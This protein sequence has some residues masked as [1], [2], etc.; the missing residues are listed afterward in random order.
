MDGGRH[1]T[2]QTRAAGNDKQR[3]S[4]PG[5]TS[6]IAS[7][8][9]SPNTTIVVSAPSYNPTGPPQ[10]VSP[11]PVPPSQPNQTSNPTSAPATQS[12]AATASLYQC[13]HCQRRYSRP[14][15]LARHIQTHTLGKRF[16]CQ[17]CGKAFARQDLLKRHVAN[18]E[19]DND[20]NKKRR[21]TDTSPGAGRVSH[22]CRPCATARVKCEEVKPCTRCRNRNLNCEYT[23]TEAGS[24]AAMHLLHL[25][26]NPH[27]T[28]S[29]PGSL[30]TSPSQ[31]AYDSSPSTAYQ[32]QQQ[33]P[34][35]AMLPPKHENG[36]LGPAH[37]VKLETGPLST[38]ENNAMDRAG[39]GAVM[40]NFE[41]GNPGVDMTLPFS[42]FLQNVIYEPEMD[43]SRITEAQGLAVLDFCD[44]SNL[45][46]NE[47][48]FG[49]LDHW[50]MDGMGNTGSN[51]SFTPRTDDSIDLV[52]MRQTLVKVW[53]ES[54]WQWAPNKLDSGYVEHPNFSV[55]SDDTSSAAFQESR[56][57]HARIVRD[58]LDQS[59]R[60]QILAI[61]L[62]TCKND[63]IMSRVA[64]SFPSLEVMDSLIHIFLASHFCQTSQWIHHGSFSM[65]SQWPEWLAV[66]AS[67]GATL[68]PVQTLRKFGF[69]LQEAVRVTIPARFEDA[70]TSIKNM[71]LVQTLILGQDIGLWSGNRRKMEIA[72]CHLLIPITMMRY[73]GK[74]QRA[75]YPVIEV[76]MS[77]EGEILE[78][79]WKVWCER[80]SWKRLLFHCFVRDAQ[81]SM[82]ALTNPS[83]S[84][85][86]L[87]LPLPEAKELWFARSAAE[88]K[89]HYLER[90]VGQSKRPPSI[91]DLFRD[92]ELLATNRQRLDLQFAISIYLHGYWALILEYLQ[93]CSVLRT[94]TWL[95]NSG[96]KS[97]EMLRSRH[98][99]LCKDLQ[100]FLLVTSD[101]HE[102]LSTQESLVLHLLM[103]NLHLSLND[104]QLFS[105]K[106]GEDQ[107][108]RVFG[109]L[110]DWSQS[111]EARQSL[112]HAGQI[113][114]QA[115]MFPQGHLKDFYAVAVHHAALACWTHGVV[116]KAS[117]KQPVPYEQEK[118]FLDGNESNLVHRFIGFNQG[119][120][121]I[122]GP[123]SRAGATEA[124]LDDPKACMEVAQEIL[125]AN[126]RDSTDL[127]PPI[128]ENLCLLIKQ[129]G[130]AA[131]A[132]SM[133]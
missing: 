45:E 124:S 33:H 110:R 94:R 52:Q 106:E 103:M 10:S 3:A 70:N 116:S 102:M 95:N 43:A 25:S 129:L 32:Q 83:M 21:R 130:H 51:Q 2:M 115:K 5:R 108:R 86:E 12:H 76:N 56:M 91:G 92:I 31:S 65:N 6:I 88:W 97:E 99:E 4:A 125:R 111:A 26:G 89:M 87:T 93:L 75:S 120:P 117:G 118:V 30:A 42:D 126:F 36:P 96:G 27:A 123:M 46:L 55:P 72:E 9:P 50:N 37:H 104:L 39:N 128:V 66:A 101:W 77:D 64:S 24:A 16:A 105:G 84:Y 131:W 85:S 121:V 67:A 54:P 100:S 15:H 7:T 109:D 48:D 44:N 98:A 38:Q 49:L 78:N 57:K 18:H 40:V 132:V 28:T 34:Q 82:T 81:T 13:A 22:A 63:N 90:T 119:R 107:A 59:G 62:S 41:I 58:K 73:R 112:W 29:T 74:F 23:S 71:G 68:T 19:N 14:E 17:I 69:A 114:R 133:E 60:D 80:E 20:P 11:S 1:S 47:V 53:T 122:L 8:A 113:L 35:H 61:V 79:K 127:H